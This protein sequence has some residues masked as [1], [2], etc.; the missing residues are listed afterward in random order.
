MDPGA[1]FEQLYYQPATHVCEQGLDVGSRRIRS[2]P[3][4]TKLVQH[5]ISFKSIS[6]CV[7]GRSGLR[8]LTSL[9]ALALNTEQSFVG[10][11]PYLTV[12]SLL[13]LA[14]K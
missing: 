13:L 5:R 10:A 12:V 6:E 14:P 9:D 7:Y 11:V 8:L 1:R 3:L 2:H 4:V